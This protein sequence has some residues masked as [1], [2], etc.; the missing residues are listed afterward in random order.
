[1]DIHHNNQGFAN[2]EARVKGRWRET[3]SN[4]VVQ[5]VGEEIAGGLTKAVDGFLELEDQITI[6]LETGRLADIDVLIRAKRSMN[7]G[8]HDVSLSRDQLHV[9][10]QDHHG[11]NSGPLDDR[12]PCFKEVNAFDLHVT[13]QTEAGLEFLGYSIGKTLE[14]EGPSAGKDIHPRLTGTSSQAWR[15]DSRVVNSD[16]MASHHLAGG[17]LIA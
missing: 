4:Q 13:S 3:L 16:S 6:T 5:K 12:S 1:M 10:G 8:S 7:K 17:L 14:A 9:G 15:S 2:K 11:M